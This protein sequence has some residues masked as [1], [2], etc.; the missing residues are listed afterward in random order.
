MSRQKILLIMVAALVGLLVVT[1]GLRS[2]VIEPYRELEGDIARKKREVRQYDETLAMKWD[3]IEQWQALGKRT[4]AATA[5][6]AQLLFDSKI[7]RLVQA[8]GLQRESV[9]P[10]NPRPMKNGL[11]RVPYSIQAEGNLK[12]V[13]ELLVNIYEQPYMA[14]VTMLR[15]KPANPKKRHWLSISMDL[16]TVVLP[17]SKI[18]GPIEPVEAA[19][20]ELPRARRYEQENGQAYAMVYQRKFF[21]EYKPPPP[22]P[23]PPPPVKKDPPKKKVASPPPPPPPP[24]PRDNSRIVALLSYPGQQEVITIKPGRKERQIHRLGD[25]LGG[26]VLRM[27]HPYGA[28][29]GIDGEDYVYPPGAALD[30]DDQRVPASEV[31]QIMKVLGQLAPDGPAETPTTGEAPQE[32][33]E[34]P[35]GPDQVQEQPAG[36]PQPS[37]AEEPGEP[38]PPEEQEQEDQA[39]QQDEPSEPE[40]QEEEEQPDQQDEP[41]GP[42]QEEREEQDEPA[43]E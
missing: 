23:P 26:G 32:P 16:E 6:K 25:E 9:R 39:A 42:E 30:K 15:L 22:P 4:L 43:A 12:S 20:E 24:K 3:S 2:L 14:R 38:A 37:S 41:T 19:G 21:E 10:K 36:P 31:P 8:H 34:S 7:K 5:N 29:I 17:L 1:R 33:D 28:V 11:V 27:V 18:G 35:V 40:E 13:V